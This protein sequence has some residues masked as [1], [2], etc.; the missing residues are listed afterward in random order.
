MRQWHR[1]QELLGSA[2]VT[3][4]AI[5]WEEEEEEEEAVVV[6]AQPS[7]VQS[8]CRTWRRLG[9]SSALNQRGMWV[10]AS[11]TAIR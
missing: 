4:Y 1:V 7:P 5:D 6:L 10:A 8:K 2:T 3:R 9:R 11:A